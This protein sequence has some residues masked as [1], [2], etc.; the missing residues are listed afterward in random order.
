MARNRDGEIV[1]RAAAFTSLR[2]AEANAG[3][4]RGQRH[5]GS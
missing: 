5:E 1:V 4:E 2:A 3:A